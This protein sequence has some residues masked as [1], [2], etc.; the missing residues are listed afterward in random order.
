MSFN[1][2]FVHQGGWARSLLDGR[3]R[4]AMP[5]AV[6]PQLLILPPF[7]QPPRKSGKS[8]PAAGDA[9][10]IGSV[11]RALKASGRYSW[12]LLTA[13]W[14]VTADRAAGEPFCDH[15]LAIARADANRHIPPSSAG[16]GSP[17][18]IW[19]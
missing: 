11:I 18:R 13:L 12:I 3:I 10:E 14:R 7:G 1:V 6:I 15:T 8:A 17:G 2:D 9:G 16:V 5:I 19:L 4:R